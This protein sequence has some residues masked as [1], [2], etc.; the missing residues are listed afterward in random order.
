MFE[1]ILGAHAPS[2]SDEDIERIHRLWLN[3]TSEPGT[4][5]LHHKDIVAAA[6]AR[7]EHDLSGIERNLV[8]AQL[9]GTTSLE[10]QD[11]RGNDYY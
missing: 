9:L 1:V 6:L 4:E 5:N 3:I 10:T 7:L 8:I 2:L 11:D